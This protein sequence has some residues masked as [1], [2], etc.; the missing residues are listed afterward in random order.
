MAIDRSEVRDALLGP[1]AT[2]QV[3]A[4]SH[5]GAARRNNEDCALVG[6][7]VLSESTDPTPMTMTLQSVEPVIV[8]VADGLGGHGGGELAAATAI[9]RVAQDAIGLTSE[10]AVADAVRQASSDVQQQAA[11]TRGAHDM[12]TTIV[13]LAI[14]PEQIF[15]FN[16]GDS[17]AF[18]LEDG[19]LLQIVT[20]DSPADTAGI[21]SA[22]PEPRDR[23]SV[24]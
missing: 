12:G 17:P 16:V 15:C 6:G 1:Q 9:R 19:Y 11:A 21:D 10:E 2:A 13:G 20:L 4:L 24:V 5:Q 8:A 23:K 3:A 18:R 22:N 7:F 14:T